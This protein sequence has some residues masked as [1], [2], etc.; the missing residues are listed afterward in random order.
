MKKKFVL[1]FLALALTAY[2]QG[3]FLG[4]FFSQKKA[5]LK[6]L[7]KQL[8][9]MMVYVKQTEAGYEKAR[10]ALGSIQQLKKGE[11]DLHTSY[12][13]SLS[14]VNPIIANDEKVSAISDYRQSILRWFG[15]LLQQA[16]ASEE[17]NAEEKNYLHSMYQQLVHACSASMDELNRAVTR[18][19]WTMT[20]AQRLRCIDQVYAVMKNRYAFTRSI[21]GDLGW[22]AT[23]RAA[24]KNNIHSIQQGR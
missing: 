1:S 22:L 10:A 5:D 6:A 19:V 11:L 7:E 17:V 24:E 18:G 14:E 15:Q 13:G 20:D 16:N 21:A 2:G 9:A 4:G 23:Q 12:F 8:A 3:Q